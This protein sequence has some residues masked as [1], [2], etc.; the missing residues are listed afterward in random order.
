LRFETPNSPLKHQMSRFKK[1]W[2]R[3][4]ET[5]EK[6]G[7]LALWKAG[8][9][10]LISPVFKSEEFYLFGRPVKS[11]Y[12]P[13]EPDQEK[14]TG[15]IVSFVVSSNEEADRIE[16]EGYKFRSSPTDWNVGQG[17]YARWLDAGAIAICTFVGK[18]FAAINWTI[19]SKKVQKRITY[20]V[21][22]NYS[23]HEAI[24]RGYW[25]NPK[26][27]GQGLIKYTVRNRDEF[28]ANIGVKITKGPILFSNMVGYRLSKSLG[29]KEY[30]R[31]RSIRIFGWQF[32]KE[33]LYD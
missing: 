24:T 13:S 9:L 17:S 3:A 33:T 25:V 31:A 26:Y 30:G 32:W 12:G 29:S 16:K 28:L 4:R 27:R 20:P 8:V 21:K 19:L 6:R 10:Y 14:A 2:L 7:L 5:R 18:E 22:I 1:L 15:D 11:D 23:D